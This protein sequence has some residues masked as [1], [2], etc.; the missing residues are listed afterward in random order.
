[1]AAPPILLMWNQIESSGITNPASVGTPPR[2][3]ATAMSKPP[4]TMKGTM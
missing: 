2:D 1:M 4:V 3:K